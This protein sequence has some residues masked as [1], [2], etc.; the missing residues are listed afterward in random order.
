MHNRHAV[1]VSH[2]VK[3]GRLAASALEQR[4]G[5]HNAERASRQAEAARQDAQAPYGEIR[6]AIAFPCAAIAAI[7]KQ[8]KHSLWT[9]DIS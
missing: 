4:R 2:N 9:M 3:L 1:R 7:F 5:L 8:M 6:R